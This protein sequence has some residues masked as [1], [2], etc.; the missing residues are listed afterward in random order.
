VALKVH[1]TVVP[2]P[3]QFDGSAAAALLRAKP[4][5][6]NTAPAPVNAIATAIGAART[7][8]LDLIR[9]VFCDISVRVVA[10]LSR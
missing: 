9:I 4:P 6:A 1:V 3:E 10:D 8:P 5:R 2:E 7:E